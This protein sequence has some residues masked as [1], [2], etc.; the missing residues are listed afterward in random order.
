MALCA[1]NITHYRCE[2]VKVEGNTV[3]KT[4]FIGPLLNRL[5]G[6]IIAILLLVLFAAWMTSGSDENTQAENE[7][8]EPTERSMVAKVQ[9]VTSSAREV[10]KTL[11]I[12]GITQAQR[13]VAVRSEASGRVTQL[14]KKQGDTVTAGEIIAQLDLKDIP[15]RIT[16]AEAFVNQTRLEYEGAQ[17]LV[18][19]GLQNQAQVA[20]ALARFEQANANLESLRQQQ[21]NTIIRAP[22][23]GRI[24]NFDLELGSFVQMGD[25]IGEIYD[26]SQLKFVG[27]VSEKDISSL[28]IGQQGSVELINGDMADATV[29]YIGSVTNPA[30]RTFEVELTV[31]SVSRN[32]SGV[33]SVAEVQLNMVRGH[34]I[35]PALLFIDDAGQLGLKT[36]DEDNRVGF[37]PVDIL[38]SDTDGVWVSGLPEQAHIIV[39]GQGFVSIGD[40]TEPNFSEFDMTVAVGL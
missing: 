36:L 15:A 27:A 34:Y 16:E 2:R 7:T 9:A 21:N 29:S 19:Q 13:S 12:N 20:S 40:M 4:T 23:A 14:R 8:S 10:Q 11:E 24:E 38:R 37:Y 22:F 25:M 6:P 18:N 3:S 31:P 26:Y 17:R 35:S 28:S 32:V 5:A 33:T 1:E 30:T 39:V